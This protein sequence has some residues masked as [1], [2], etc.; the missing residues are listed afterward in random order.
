MHD[1]LKSTLFNTPQETKQMVESLDKIPDED[2][3]IN[4]NVF[5][6]FILE[7]RSVWCI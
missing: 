4:S 7:A 3:C 6:E 5:Q 2:R 1:L